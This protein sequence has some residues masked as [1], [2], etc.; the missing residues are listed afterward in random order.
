MLMYTDYTRMMLTVIAVAKTN[1]KVV[2]W[3]KETIIGLRTSQI[4]SSMSNHFR[5]ILVFLEWALSITMHPI[6][7][8]LQLMSYKQTKVVTL[9]AWVKE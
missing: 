9:L 7:Q 3:V 2:S 5:K 4:E 1:A 6:S 8:N